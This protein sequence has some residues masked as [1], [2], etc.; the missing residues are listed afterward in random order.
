[1]CDGLTNGFDTLIGKMP[2]ENKECK[3]LLSAVKQPETVDE[4]IRSELDN[5]FL[6]GP[7]EKPPFEKFRVSP[8]GVAEGKYSGKKRLIVDL[9]SLHNDQNHESINSLIDKDMCSLKYVK[10]DDA[11]QSIKKHGKGAILCKT[12]ISNAFKLIPIKPEQMPFYM[13]RWRN[14]Y[15]VY[16]RLVFGS[17]SSPKFFDNLSQVI[18]WIVENN[19]GISPIFHLLNDF[20]TVHNSNVDGHR[21]MALL[22]LIFGRLQVPLSKPKTV[23]PTT[24]LEYLGVIL[25]S[26]KMEA[27]LPRDKIDRI[28]Y[29]IRS[30]LNRTSCT[31]REMLQLL[32]H[33]NFASRVVVPGRSFVSYL[34]N[35]TTSVRELHHFIH[36]NKE[37]KEDLLM[38][39]NFL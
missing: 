25:D 19:Y 2:S 17:R 33:F 29:F 16:T 31:K 21:T 28:I 34:I 1:M 12:D 4:L 14:L 8:I 6:Q 22:T 23:G 39:L 35:I 20:L 38:W 32:G 13:I 3:N 5:K 7:F 10:V 24:V 15:Y 9:S 36:L 37:C 11:I 18:C 26:E 27:R 30:L